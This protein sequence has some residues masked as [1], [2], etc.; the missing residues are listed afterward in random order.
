MTINTFFHWVFSV[1]TLLKN[2][3]SDCTS[4]RVYEQDFVLGLI[5]LS[6]SD[7]VEMKS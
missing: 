1:F 2:V 4:R 5:I 3:Y 6:L 7:Y